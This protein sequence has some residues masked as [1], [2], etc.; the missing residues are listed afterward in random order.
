MADNN[1]PS[2]ESLAATISETANALSA[3]LK[4]SACPAPSFAEDG[5]VEYPKLPELNGLRFQLIDAAADLYRLA[6]GPTDNSMFAPLHVGSP[7]L[8]TKESDQLTRSSSI[9]TPPSS[10]EI[11]TKVSLPESLVRRVLKYAITIRYF[12][13]DPSD[14]DRVVHTSLSAV[15]A[16]QYLIR[17]WFRHHFDEARVAGVHFAESFEKFSAGKDKPSEEPIES[18]FSLANVDKLKTPESFWDYLNREA[19]GKPKGW[20][21]TNFAESMQAASSASA[22]R[23]EDLLKIGYDWAQLGDVTLVDVG[24]S[25]GH[26]AVHL[27]RTFPS[28]KKIVVQDLPEVQAAFDERLPEELKSRVSFEP[29]DFFGPQNTPGDVY[30]LKTILH[31]WPDKYAAKILAN[32]VP[33]LKSGSRILLVEAVGLPEG[34]EPPFQMLGRTFA[35]A[36]LHMLGVFNSLE[37]NLEDWKKLLG[38]V[39]ERLEIGHVSEVPGALHNFIEIKFRG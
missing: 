30:M 26:D 29:H 12:A 23:A 21:A 36:D 7:T 22:I 6:L 3:K 13:R 18:P 20:R 14:K 39:D 1:N 8:H 32:L 24:G 38:D 4:E 17:S 34:V 27:A 25:S 15:P 33:R 19:E 28:L 37:R 9:M 35:A 10:T 16:K 31:D 5:L 11:A 2:L